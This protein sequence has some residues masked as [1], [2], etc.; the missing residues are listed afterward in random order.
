MKCALLTVT[1]GDRFKYLK[2]VL[3]VIFCEGKHVGEI[4]IVDNNSKN[5]TEIKEFLEL[6]KNIK[7]KYI[8]FNEN[9]G[10]SGGF[11]A[12]IE[13]FKNSEHNFLII[14][15][16]DNKPEQ[17]FIKQYKEK[18][19]E[20]SQ[21]YNSNKIIVSG[22][23]HNLTASDEVIR[24]SE[25]FNP[26]SFVGFSFLDCK[27]WKNKLLKNKNI[28]LGKKEIYKVNYFPYGGTML[29]KQ[30]VNDVGLPNPYFLV[31]SDDA[32]YS[33]RGK[34]MGYI[35]FLITTI[36]ITDLQLTYSSNFPHYLYADNTKDFQAYFS[37]RNFIIS[38]LK[39]SV[40]NKYLFYTNITIWFIIINLLVLY[41]RKF[42]I[43]KKDF[44]KSKLILKAI[45]AGIMENYSP[46][47]DLKLP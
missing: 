3:Q 33:L 1:Y 17:G 35:Y 16:D 40:T 34:G 8:R 28:L 22:Y 36:K 12:G 9:K 42:Y 46:P 2:E 7:S 15:D 27:F 4:I 6:H 30:F 29:T 21:I 44:K 39:N 10:S 14:L 23:R 11:G 32:E 5:E 13:Y 25:N 20:L 45:K 24:A 47:R 37:I 26:N 31:Y 41:K 19:A 18:Y 43:Y 38:A